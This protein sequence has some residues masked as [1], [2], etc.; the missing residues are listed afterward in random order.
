MKYI[1]I[2]FFSLQILLVT[3][4]VI[5]YIS[6]RHADTE[7][8]TLDASERRNVPGS[9]IQLSDGVTH[10][11]LSGPDTGRLVVLVHGFSVPYYIWDSTFS[12]LVRE[13]FRVLRYDE[14]G[15]GFSDR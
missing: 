8:I 9:F 10:Y 2:G 3:G 15:R 1:R 4:I 12:R 5:A 13:G 14:F 6:F 11:E 7:S